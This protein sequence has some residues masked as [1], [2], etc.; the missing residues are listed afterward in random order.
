MRVK[1]VFYCFAL[2]LG[3]ATIYVES[4]FLVTSP[5]IYREGSTQELPVSIFS[6]P[7]PWLV[8]ATLS[9]SK[10]GDFDIIASDEAQFTSLSDGTLKLKIPR[11]LIAHDKTS[12]KAKLT[13]YGGPVGGFNAFLS[14][15]LITIE[16][17]KTSIFIQTD[18]PIYKPGQTVHMRVVGTDENL[19]PLKGKISRVTVMNP[20]NVRIMQW[21]NLDFVVGMASLKFQLSSQPDLGNWKIVAVYKDETKVQGFKVDKYVLPKFEVTIT[22][23]PFVSFKE[24]R[25]ITARICAQ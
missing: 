13:V 17:P 7:V 19:K 1:V 23:P 12:T 24:K 3:Q 14:S 15:E 25:I 5:R 8:N 11:T 6:E 22:P 10:Y 16:I 4:G 18:K 20:S 21:D 9:H 2:I